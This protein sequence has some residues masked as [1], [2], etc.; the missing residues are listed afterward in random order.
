MA[1]ALRGPQFVTRETNRHD[2]ALAKDLD[3]QGDRPRR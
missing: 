2:F 1:L 3:L